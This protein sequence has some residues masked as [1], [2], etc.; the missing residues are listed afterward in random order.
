M[1][2]IS[3]NCNLNFKG[4]FDIIS[5]LKPNLLIDQECEQLPKDYFPNAEYLWVGRNPKKGLGVLIF[6]GVG[7]ISPEYD[8]KYIEFLPINS[9]FGHLL[10]VWAFNHRAKKYGEDVKGHILQALEKY[11]PILADENT[12][13][14]IGDFNNSIVWDKPKSSLTFQKAAEKFEAFGMFSAYHK[15]SGENFGDETK[16]TL[17]HTKKQEKTYH[18]DYMFTRKNASV[19][20]G[21]YEHWI[22]YSDHMPLVI[23]LSNE[24]I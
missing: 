1:R 23:N 5:A 6:D 9:D 3:W 2:V 19:E 22:Q 24:S 8:N 11:E 14:V 20:I 16:A 21:N 15:S 13:G 10:G 18:I 12:I 4:K 17:Y 7:S